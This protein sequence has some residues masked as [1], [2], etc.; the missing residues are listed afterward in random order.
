MTALSEAI[1]PGEMDRVLDKLPD[2]Y[3]DLLKKEP[4]GPGFPSVHP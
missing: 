1:T 3:K 2:P 4:Q